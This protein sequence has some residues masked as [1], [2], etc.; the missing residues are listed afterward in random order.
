M[1]FSH[2]VPCYLAEQL[3]GPSFI[4]LLL[5]LGGHA[6]REIG[7]ARVTA[8]AGTFGLLSI[9]EVQP[10]AYG[11]TWL[12]RLIFFSS[13]IETVLHSVCANWGVSCDIKSPLCV[14]LY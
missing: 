13:C 5:V 6:L 2:V 10:W 9:Q 3:V 11:V 12:F 7:H 8:L 4:L 14:P 1:A